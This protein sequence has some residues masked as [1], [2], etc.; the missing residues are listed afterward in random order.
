MTN[1]KGGT[2]KTTVAINLAGALNARG[3]DVL[4]V[5]TDPQGNATEGLGLRDAYLAEPPTFLDALTDPGQREVVNDLI[6]EHSEMDVLPA[7]I[8]LRDAERELTIAG[9][10]AELSVT[11]TGVDPSV[12]SGLA[13]NV[14]PSA[15]GDAHAKDQLARV[16]DAVDH[17][18]DYV[19]VDSPPYFGELLDA[20]IFAAPNIIVPAL[21]ESASQAGIEM[22]FEEVDR[23]GK[24]T[25]TSIK[26]LGAVANRV[27]TTN[28][29][30]RM[31]A[32]LEDAF[33]GLPVWEV[34]KRVAL[35]EA[36]ANGQ[37]VFEYS[38]GSDASE[39]FAEIAAEVDSRF[40]KEPAA[41]AP[42]SGRAL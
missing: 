5:D 36:F 26:V 13:I 42:V 27:E 32:W 29:D 34:R 11:E 12:L 10:M 7:S 1:A 2:G 33:R 14:T 17:E 20:S 39:W 19:I 9:L 28:E 3:H 8:D 25:G 30:D 24:D 22:L 23:L 31:I 35:Q 6:V 37:S 38:A 16:L 15:V 41:D 18:Y 21:T 4:L 40:G